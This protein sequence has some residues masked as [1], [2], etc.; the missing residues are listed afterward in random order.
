[1][2]SYLLIFIVFPG[3]SAPRAQ[4]HH[5]TSRNGGN[6]GHLFHVGLTIIRAEFHLQSMRILEYVF[7]KEPKYVNLMLLQVMLR[8]MMNSSCFWVCSHAQL[9]MFMLQGPI[10]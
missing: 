6:K 8:V 10:P 7:H 3:A 5:H 4:C 9:L 2:E 1:M